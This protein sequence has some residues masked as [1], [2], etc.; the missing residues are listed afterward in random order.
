LLELL[1]KSLEFSQIARFYAIIWFMPATKIVVTVALFTVI[2]DFNFSSVPRSLVSLGHLSEK[3]GLGLFVVTRR[4]NE[5]ALLSLTDR[6]VLPASDVRPSETVEDAAHRLVREDLGVQVPVRLR[7][8]RI[9]DDPKREQDQRVISINYWGFAN[10]H[11]VAPILGGKEQVGLELVNSSSFL[12]DWALKNDLEDYDGVCRF[13]LRSAPLENRA[14]DRKLAHQIG[15]GPILDIDHD[16][17]VFYSWRKLRYAFRGRLDPFRYLGA[18][19]LSEA[20][21]LSDLKEL[22]DVCRGERT[23]VDQF[24]R[25]VLSE[26]SFIAE[27]DAKEAKQ[28]RPGKPATLYSL[29]DWAN[30]TKDSSS[31][32][33]YSD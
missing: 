21:R 13:G 2:E 18:T 9:F 24:R 3:F 1:E 8:E 14:H 27:S 20:F 17:M 25:S 33:D 31:S 22:N 4:T 5:D 7:Q 16:E 23:Q 10:L 15:N 32:S 26:S 12:D 19:A 6:R 29:R 11:D 28:R 30:P